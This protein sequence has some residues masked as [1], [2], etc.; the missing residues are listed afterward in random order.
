M[1]N[2]R[3]PRSLAGR[4]RMATQRNL[5]NEFGSVQGGEGRQ[6]AQA[7]GTSGQEPSLPPHALAGFADGTFL[8]ANDASAAAAAT[9]PASV[10]SRS[11]FTTTH[12]LHYVFLFVIA[13]TFL[14]MLLSSFHITSLYGIGPA[15]L[16]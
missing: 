2:N 4:A 12:A 13:P 1:I 3:G 15:V 10:V 6:A 11:H 7:P 14:H 8:L 16:C 5:E 9:A